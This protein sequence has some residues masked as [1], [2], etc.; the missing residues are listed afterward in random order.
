MIV[1]TIKRGGRGMPIVEDQDDRYR[2]IQSLYFLNDKNHPKTWK[3]DVD[4][5]G[6][7]LHFQRPDSW[8]DERD[9]YVDIL[10]YCLL[11]NH[12]HLLLR[13]SGEWCFGLH[14]GAK[15]QYYPGLQ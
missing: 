12:H 7:G 8:P 14:E 2:Y 11:D 10:S 13:T 4:A 9:P 3:L 1:Q 6:S 15:L 5:V